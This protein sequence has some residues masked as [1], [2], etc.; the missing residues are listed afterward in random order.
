MAQP[1]INPDGVNYK[2]NVQVPLGG[3]HQDLYPNSA[4]SLVYTR[5]AYT[6]TYM[7]APTL[8]T[9]TGVLYADANGN[10][11]S[12]ATTFY[13]TAAT[14]SLVIG[15]QAPINTVS[16]YRMQIVGADATSCLYVADA[17]GST[18]QVGFVGRNASGTKASPTATAQFG[19]L[20]TLGGIGY[21]DAAAYTGIVASIKLLALQNFT[22]SAQGT[23]VT[24]SLTP[25]GST[26]A[27][28]VFTQYGGGATYFPLLGTTASAANAFLDSGSTPANQLLRSTSSLRY[29]EDVEDMYFEL[30]TKIISEVRPIWYRSKCEAD[31]VSAPGSLDKRQSYFGIAAE[32]MAK[33]DPRFVFWTYPEEC[34]EYKET[35]S[36]EEK[37]T[38]TKIV[39]TPSTAAP[40]EAYR[41]REDGNFDKI[42]IPAPDIITEVPETIIT[43]PSMLESCD[44]VL[45]EGVTR[46]QMIP[47]GVQYDRLVVP[48]L[49]VVQNQQEMIANC[50]EQ[51]QDQ[52]TSITDFIKRIEALELKG[53]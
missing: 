47:D 5:P 44:R 34:Y 7:I 46:E 22:A 49:L 11:T 24:T 37:E 27:A 25:N 48:L 38:I 3:L 23:Y 14:N 15:A 33:I 32:E 28:S 51:I 45:K 42:L 6:G 12:A 39:T 20:M 18:A 30:A 52:Q 10:V 40:T 43:K 26:T 8:P 41:Q 50:V 29:K 2:F 31:Q 19:Q 9:A 4:S 36:L 53:E 17:F 16:G 13:F 21:N 35:W 1:Y